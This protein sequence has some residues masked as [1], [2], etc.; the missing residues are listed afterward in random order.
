MPKPATPPGGA[1]PQQKSRC[2]LHCKYNHFESDEVEIHSWELKCLDCGWRQTIAFRSDD[3]D[4]DW[5]SGR[6]SICPFCEASGLT[7]G[8]NPCSIERANPP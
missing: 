4:A 1:C 8:K 7:P 3:E 2:D 6:Q 5:S